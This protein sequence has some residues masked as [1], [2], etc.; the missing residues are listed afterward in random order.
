[1]LILREAAADPPQPGQL[2][3]DARLRLF[4]EVAWEGLVIEDH[5]VV[6]DANPAL[7]RIYGY[8]PGEMISK[9]SW[10]LFA[11]PESREAVRRHIETESEETYEAFALRKDGSQVEVEIQG[12]RIEYGGRRLRVAAVRDLTERRLLERRLQEAEKM[13]AVGRLAGGVAHDFNNLLTVIA[14]DGQKLF[15]QLPPES[16]LHV[17]AD[18]I[19]GAAQRAGG[20]AH[21]LLA[22]SRRQFLQPQVIDLNAVLHNMEM[23][24]RR[25]AGENST[26]EFSLAPDL[27]PVSV[28]PAQIGQVVVNLVLNARDAMPQG[29][30][31][32][33]RT[34]NSDS[35]PPEMQGN[36]GMHSSVMLAVS[37]TG[38]GMDIETRRHLFE[39]FFTTKAKGTGLGLATSYG[40]IKQHGGEISVVTEPGRGTEFRIYLNPSDQPV[41]ATAPSNP[42]P[43]ARGSEVI[44]LVEDEG[45][46]RKMLREVL[47]EQG[48]QV[49]D[50]ASARSALAV[51]AAHEGPID[52]LLT[53]VIMPEVNGYDLAERL[54]AARPDTKVLFMSGYTDHAMRERGGTVE[55]LQKPFTPTVLA[56]RIRDVLG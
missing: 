11:G 40:I 36:T 33:I 27:T 42:E 48:Y 30:R 41:T 7:E 47:T 22:F 55:F 23:L 43:A 1:L 35:L 6:L 21:Q 25:L 38:V 56:E 51:A 50:A 31:I 5:G 16:P 49:L 9:T 29:G 15:D 20:L 53:D 54:R 12:R 28:D 3:G 14:G 45:V 24:L 52:L 8:A 4:S 26:L 10:D 46:V 37:D 39:P 32:E 19:L 44:L 18:E 2:I 17:A 13:E 34:A